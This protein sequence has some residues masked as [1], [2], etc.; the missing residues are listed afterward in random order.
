MKGAVMIKCPRTGRDIK[1]GIEADQ[2]SFGAMP[3][4]FSRSFCAYCQVQ[5]EWFAKDAWV[6][7]SV[8]AAEAA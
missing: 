6:C 2:A 1:T 7:E 4:F 8:A 5:H 3:V